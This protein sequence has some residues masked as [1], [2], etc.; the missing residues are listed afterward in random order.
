MIDRDYK[1]EWVAQESQR[2]ANSV[3]SWIY[4]GVDTRDPSE[5]KIGLT[6]GQLGTRASS[7]QNPY[8][9]LY[10][11][12]KV[13]DGTS[14]K[15]LENI[16]TAIKVMLTQNYVAVPHYGS[17]KLSEVFKVSPQEMTEVVNDFLLEKFSYYMLCYHCHER[18]M[19]IIQ[20]WENDKYLHGGLNVPYQ[21][22]DISNPPI[23]FECL[24]PPG[25]GD[26]DCKCWQ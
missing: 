8:Y 9:T 24:T 14:A 26:L 12:F 2:Q 17:G 22:K 25:C 11:A 1:S 3:T 4:V 20:G 5:A 6:G 16:E 13:K 18:D 7:S 15:D 21:P 19:G 10:R 23:A